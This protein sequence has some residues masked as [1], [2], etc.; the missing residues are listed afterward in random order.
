[1]ATAVT[2][3]FARVA[4]TLALSALVVT[5]LSAVLMLVP[6]HVAHGLSFWGVLAGFL[7]NTYVLT[8]FTVLAVLIAVAH[9]V[10]TGQEY[11]AWQ[12]IGMSVVM[13]PVAMAGSVWMAKRMMDAAM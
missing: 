11:A 7:L 4:F 5:L 1:M 10:R 12:R 2:S 13:L 8:P 3:P 9:K 6:I